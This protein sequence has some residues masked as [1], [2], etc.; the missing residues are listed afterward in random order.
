M[1][2]ASERQPQNGTRNKRVSRSRPSFVAETSET[3]PTF[4]IRFDFPPSSPRTLPSL[5]N[6]DFPGGPDIRV[7]D[8]DGKNSRLANES[9]F[10]KS[11]L[12]RSDDGGSVISVDDLGLSAA[13]ISVPRVPIKPGKVMNSDQIRAFFGLNPGSGSSG[14]TV[15]GAICDTIEARL[16]E[17]KMNKEE[18]LPIDAFEA[19]LNLDVITSLLLERFPNSSDKDLHQRLE[20]IVG[21]DEKGCRRRI[22]AILVCMGRFDSI[23]QFIEAG[24]CDHDFPLTKTDRKAFTTQT[25]PE[26]INTTLLASWARSDITLLY[27]FQNQLFVPFFNIEEGKLRSYFLARSTVLPWRALQYKTSGGNAMVHQVQIHPS[28]HN[29]VQSQVRDPSHCALFTY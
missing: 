19:I 14:T 16:E 11:Q 22:L 28:H 4:E 2:L 29:F 26:A 15:E 3:W 10:Q 5:S 27:Q 25:K 7:S 20:D 13:S 17:S 24:V 21:T 8:P 12:S 23:H 18:Y 6:D 1:S 9:D